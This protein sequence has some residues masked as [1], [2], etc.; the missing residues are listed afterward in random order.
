MA[1]PT[2]LT[3]E[4]A[5]GQQLAPLVVRP[6]VVV[7]VAAVLLG[8]TTVGF[9]LLAF[10]PMLFPSA[11]LAALAAV[12]GFGA[13]ASGMILSGR[14]RAHAPALVFAALALGSVAWSV[15]PRDSLDA[16]GFLGLCLLGYVCASEL[17]TDAARRLVLST[18]AG[19]AAFQALVAVAQQLLPAANP[20]GWLDHRAF[21]AILTRSA[22]TVFD[23]NRLGALL[24]LGLPAA[25][26]L[27]VGQRRP[28]RLAIYLLAALVGL[29]LVFTYSRAA[30]LGAVVAL[31]AWLVLSGRGAARR[32]W[33]WAVVGFLLSAVLAALLAWLPARQ[34]AL[35]VVEDGDSS[36][37]SRVAVWRDA[38]GVIAERP[39]LGAGLD[40]FQEA[41]LAH[42]NETS[43]LLPCRQAH[44]EL[45]GLAADLGLLGAAAFL[46]LVAAALARGFRHWRGEGVSAAPAGV[47]GLLGLLATG[48]FESTLNARYLPVIAAFWLMLGLL[49]SL[50]QP[51]GAQA[52]AGAAEG[53]LEG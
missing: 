3:G 37:A 15:A 4:A 47:A 35:S 46:W 32:H 17:R 5:G 20:P 27:S 26:A 39:L 45:L 49:A 12:L 23:P 16:A 48:A 10:S 53:S 21:P 38:L 22:G 31:A 51:G 52:S 42:L 34:R 40:A 2:S 28:A 14:L 50:P 30:W 18:L 11:G 13:A 36:L 6:V 25:L 8:L 29:G 24:V 7:V 33:R 41:R 1:V 43:A 19:L 44:N 9:P